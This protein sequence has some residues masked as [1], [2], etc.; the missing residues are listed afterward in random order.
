MIEQHVR[1]ALPASVGALAAAVIAALAFSSPAAIHVPTFLAHSLGDPQHSVSLVRT[2]AK[3]TTVKL[4]DQGGVSVQ[5]E[6]G[7]TIGLEA[8]LSGDAWAMYRHGV[9]RNTDSGAE[10]ITVRP[11]TVEES[12]VVDRHH[13]KHVWSWQLHSGEW[14]PRIDLVGGVSFASGHSVSAIVLDRPVILDARGR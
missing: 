13:G 8:L 5:Q 10:T 14:A 4:L 9:A 7:A 2:P 6:R 12:L 1:I 3:N 11:G